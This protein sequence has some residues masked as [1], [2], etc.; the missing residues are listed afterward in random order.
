[1]ITLIIVNLLWYH[2]ISELNIH[3]DSLT[4]LW[5]TSFSNSEGTWFT[6]GLLYGRKKDSAPPSNFPE[7]RGPWAE[8]L[9]LFVAHV[10]HSMQTVPLGHTAFR[11][12]AWKE[13]RSCLPLCCCLDL[14]QLLPHRLLNRH[15]LLLLCGR[16]KNKS[17]DQTYFKILCDL[18]PHLVYC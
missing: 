17:L 2:I 10:Q 15:S 16:G 8:L 6:K 13:C 9:V 4:F 3:T 5:V 7:P 12:T 18:A 14:N 1:M 11:K